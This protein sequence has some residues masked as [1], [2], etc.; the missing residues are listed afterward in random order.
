MARFINPVTQY[1]D[2]SGDLLASGLLYFFDS[3]TS[4]AKT[5][6]ADSGLTTANPHP[7]VLNADGTVPNIFF[8]GTAKVILTDS[9]D[10]Q[11]WERDPVG[12]TNVNESI[13]TWAA[14]VT[15]SIN[16][17][18]EGSDGNFY[19][20]I[21]SGN[22]GND[23][24]TSAAFWSE[25]VFIT[26][27]NTNET[28]DIGDTVRG[29]DGLLYKSLTAS[30]TGNDPIGDLTNWDTTSPPIGTASIQDGAVTE[31]KLDPTLVEKITQEPNLI[32]NSAFDYWQEGTSFV[33]VDNS[34]TAD[35]W[36]VG[37]GTGGAP[38]LNVDQNDLAPGAVAGIDESITNSLRYDLTTAPTGPT[39]PS[40]A[41]RIEGVGTA[42]NQ[43]IFVSFWANVTIGDPLSCTLVMRQNFGT[44]G[45]PSADVDTTEAFSITGTGFQLYKFTVSVPTIS[46]KTIGTDGNDY[47]EMQI[48]F[49]LN[50]VLRVNFTAFSLKVNS[51]AT[52][53]SR[54]GTTIGG[55]LPLIQRFWEKSYSL[56]VAPGTVSNLGRYRFQNAVGV[57]GSG[58]AMFNV[59]WKVTKR[60][61]PTVVAYA[62]STGTSGSITDSANGD[63]VANVNDA[64][65][66]G[67][68][69]SNGAAINTATT[70][71]VY[72]HY[73]SDARL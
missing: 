34:Y 29:T 61:A 62:S 67:V 71:F 53:Y 57:A 8:S 18:V 31:A 56:D 65:M 40:M 22:I 49:P 55:D 14:D 52:A 39:P 30:N 50:T 15:Y 16:S 58:V 36:R 2:T 17:I 59:E 43:T 32:I 38:V 69:I 28:Y 60:T 44:G 11:I 7:V 45:S 51:N 26:V 72:M 35:L 63:V 27:W 54:A 73:T 4:D 48:Q 24:T 9:A 66:R 33:A 19:I 20:S 37:D 64:S 1:Q 41:H 3:G 46:G 42:A 6:Y 68:N 23:P 21:Q 10:V 70:T 47:L 13:A 5:T 12:D 25:L